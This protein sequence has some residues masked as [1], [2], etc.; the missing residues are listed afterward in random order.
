M[1]ELFARMLE[2]ADA[3][4]PSNNFPGALYSANDRRHSCTQATAMPGS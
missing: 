1:H 2:L 3:G 4:T